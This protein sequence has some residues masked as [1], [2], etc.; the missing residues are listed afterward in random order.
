MVP[1]ASEESINGESLDGYAYENREGD[2]KQYLPEILSETTPIKMEKEGYSISF[3]PIQE[4]TGLES[5]ADAGNV[6]PLGKEMPIAEEVSDQDSLNESMPIDGE[7]EADNSGSGGEVQ[8][9]I[10]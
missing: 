1:V 7:P 2:S 9:F 8:G 6:T 4:S 5:Q 3:Y 10:R